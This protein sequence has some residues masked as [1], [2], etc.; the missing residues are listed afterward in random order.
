MR[1][2]T[3]EESGPNDLELRGTPPG[4]PPFAE[5][6]ARHP[7][8]IFVG[9]YSRIS[10]DWR[11]NNSKK[12][13]ASA[14]SAGKGVA[15]QHR[16]NDT[17]A[18]RHG[19][20]IVHRYTDNDISASKTDLVRPDFRA[21]LRD[22]RAGRTTTGYRLDGI[23]AVDQDRIERS[24]ADWESFVDALTK[25]SGRLF[26]TPSGSMDLE[27][28]GELLKSGIQSLFN[29]VESKK[30]KRRIRDWHQ[31]LI[32][33]GLPHSGPR[34]FG[35]EEDKMTLRPAEADFLAWAI[36]ERIKGK[37]LP[38]LCAEAKRRGLTG[39]RGGEIK[40][41]TL[42]QMMTA[43]RV[44]GYR[45]NRGVLAVDGNGAPIVGKWDTIVEPQEWEAVC[46]TFGAGST[47]LHRGPSAPRVTGKPKTVKYLASQLLRCLNPVESDGV[48]RLCNGS[49]NGSPTR[50]ARSPYTYRCSAC[51]KNAVSG[52]M[53]DRQLTRLLLAK[54]SQAQVTYRKPELVW[55]MESTLKDLA[56]RLAGLEQRWMSGVVDDE[57]FYRLSPGLQAEVRKLRA[58]RARWEMENA[59]GSEEPA[60]IIRRWRS[61]EYDLAQRRKILFD[62]FLAVQVKPGQK[63][64]KRP[65]PHRLKPV[66]RR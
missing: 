18:G 11:K 40:P 44:C 23:I 55:P 12:A 53:V 41:T 15:N 33:D 14:W 36:R 20:I 35:W 42:A 62:V 51:N 17:S 49:L 6:L 39:S 38:T 65:D 32:L 31:D 46:A 66:W 29:R 34:P 19:L 7:D 13:H 3:S 2:L 16:R 54:L 43:P 9:A 60:D 48:Q 57:Q 50:S 27:E 30:K 25:K 59:A 22:L 63:G 24:A 61:G 21:M 37:A 4:L 47:Y 28:E 64:V 10:D 45:A 5:L 8:G 26:W 58:E 56:D 52:P 1:A